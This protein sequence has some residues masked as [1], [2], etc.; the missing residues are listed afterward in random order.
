MRSSQGRGRISE[1]DLVDLA[2]RHYELGEPIDSLATDHGVEPSTVRRWLARAKRSGLVRTLVVPPLNTEESSR[3][4]QD[5]RYKYELEDVVIVPGREDLL[6]SNEESAPKE[7]LVISIA[8]AAARYLEDH[9]TN[10]DTLLVPWGRMANYIGRQLKAPRPL[11]GF[12]VVPMEGVL[13]IKDDPFEANIIASS[14]AAKFGGQCYLLPAPAVVDHNVAV[15]LEQLPLVKRVL[16]LYKEA[17]VA[18]VPLASPDPKSS[19]V[20]RA[21]LLSRKA[22]EGL[23][24]RGAV[25]EIAS[26]WWFDSEGNIVA[27]QD[28]H[29]IGLGLEG[30]KQ[31]V[32]R[33][34]K[35]IAVVGASRDRIPPLRVAL[36]HRLINV[37]VTDHVTAQLL[38]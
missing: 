34:A 31:M 3:L 20:V 13:G 36:A 28:Q 5:L 16:S 35:V 26:H 21:G 1:S 23:V 8:Q 37:L 24:E 18:I 4:R 2:V 14:I 12:T 25:G 27:R 10:R 19:T 9:L 17:T 7:A 22:V 30:L 38:G 11:P 6:D 33:R 29:A 15:M 32:R